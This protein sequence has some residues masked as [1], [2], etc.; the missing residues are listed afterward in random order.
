MNVFTSLAVLGLTSVGVV[1]PE[2]PS[3]LNHLTETPVEVIEAPT[4]KSTNPLELAKTKKSE[5][6]CCNNNRWILRYN[7]SDDVDV[8]DIVIAEGGPINNNRWILRHN[9]SDTTDVS[10]IVIA[11]GG[12]INNNRWI[13]RHNDSDTTDVSDIV[14]AAVGNTTTPTPIPQIPEGPVTE[15]KPLIELAV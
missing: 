15:E 1:S 7:N 3:G 12:P 11:E 6:G 10:N 9:D 14:I 2:A 8:S 4:P 13:L 5:G